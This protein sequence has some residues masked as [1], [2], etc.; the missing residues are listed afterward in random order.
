MEEK[1]RKKVEAMQK[2]TQRRARSK[3]KQSMLQRQRIVPSFAA[4]RGCC[5]CVGVGVGDRGKDF[6][7]IQHKTARA[8]ESCPDVVK[9]LAIG[10]PNR[11]R[12]RRRR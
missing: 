8:A 12:R 9:V 7:I 2:P 3:K 1:R 11:R 6:V 5:D 4:S 10:K